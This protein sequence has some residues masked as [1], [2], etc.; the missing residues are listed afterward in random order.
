[1]ETTTLFKMASN[2]KPVVA[3]AIMKLVERGEL[4]LDDN[5]RNHIPSWNNYRS[6][7]IQVQ[8]LLNHTSGLNIP[9]VFVLPLVESTDEHPDAPSLRIQVD[10]VGDIGAEFPASS[11]YRYNNPGYQALG[12]LIELKGIPSRNHVLAARS[13]E[14]SVEA[15]MN[16]AIGDNA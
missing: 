11:G 16:S 14:P 2:T 10:R 7:Y 13:L 9:G 1:M 8:H 5:V 3:T 12:R 4:G 15:I 6:G